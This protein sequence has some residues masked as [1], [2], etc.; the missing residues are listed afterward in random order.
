MTTFR[1]NLHGDEV[2]P[3]HE[4]PAVT[5][6]VARQSRASQVMDGFTL[7]AMTAVLHVKSY[8]FEGMTALEQS[9]QPE[10]PGLKG[11]LVK[12]AH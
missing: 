2:T 3:V 4:N 1:S 6:N 8:V 12:G 7:F 9:I 10:V 5:A 11:R